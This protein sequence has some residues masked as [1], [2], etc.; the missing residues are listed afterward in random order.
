MLCRFK[1]RTNYMGL[2]KYSGKQVKITTIDDKIFSGK[3]Y[4]FIPAQD[5]VPE[6][7]SISIGDIELFETDIKDIEII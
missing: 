4:D 7:A 1:E 6:I 3:A 2:W 5:N